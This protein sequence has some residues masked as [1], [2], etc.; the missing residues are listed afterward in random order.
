MTQESKTAPRIGVL[1]VHGVGNTGHSDTL[2]D[3]GEAFAGWVARWQ[4]AR[5]IEPAYG[6]AVLTFGTQDNSSDDRVPY[7]ELTVPLDPEAQNS[8][9]WVCAEAWWASSVRPMPFLTLLWWS[10]RYLGSLVFY[11]ASNAADRL[12]RLAFGHESEHDGHYLYRLIDAVTLLGHF[13]VYTLL[14]IVGYALLIPIIILA[15]VPYEPIQNFV[16]LR[17]LKPFLQ[18][19]ASDLRVY[20]EDEIQ[21]ANMRRRVAEGVAW[22]TRPE[23]EHGGGCESVVIVAHSGGV[24]VSHGMLTDPE[25]G[26][27]ARCVRKLITLGSG[28]SKIWQVAPA[29][30]DRL[31]TPIRGPIYWMDFWASYDPVPVGWIQP[32]R[33]GKRDWRSWLPWIED[34]RPWRCIYQPDDSIIQRHAMQPRINPQPVFQPRNDRGQRTRKDV[35]VS[36]NAHIWPDSVR[37]VNR[38]DGLSDHGKY[39]DNDE[40]VLRRVAAEIQADVYIDSMFWPKPD[41]VLAEGIR[42]RRN[43][44][45]ALA[46]AR[47]VAIC[48]AAVA[49]WKWAFS[50]AVFVASTPLASIVFAFTGGVLNLLAQIP[51]VGGILVTAGSW[52]LAAL[53]LLAGAAIASLAGLLPFEIFR[54]A[55]EW[56]DQAARQ[57]LLRRAMPSWSSFRF[58]VRREE[59]PTGEQV[60]DHSMRSHLVFRT[61]NGPAVLLLHEFPGMSQSVVSLGRIIANR[62]FSEISTNPAGLAIRCIAESPRAFRVSSRS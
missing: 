15:Q 42:A 21:A 23:S 52:L 17:L 53:L 2:I 54:S 50:I 5:G 44:V 38:M 34:T 43:R 35:G 26:E 20:Y 10:L 14:A 36:E 32:P 12:L 62:G 30:L 19:N 18:Y 3:F 47:I 9:T 58:P 39:F 13:V 6:K 56:L 60:A 31:F 24:W 22:L 8:Q 59:K 40:E 57:R 11:L 51:V 41:E 4:R 27:Q 29:T 1:F 28:L 55:W 49:V 45:G 37:V 48:L 7:A 33:V 16:L 25:Y 46:A 61:G